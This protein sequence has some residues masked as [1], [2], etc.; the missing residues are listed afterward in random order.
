MAA[1]AAAVARP[2]PKGGLTVVSQTNE[3]QMLWHQVSTAKG[4]HRDTGS[5]VAAA[6]KKVGEAGYAVQGWKWA[7]TLLRKDVP[8]MQSIV[9]ELL[10]VLQRR[11]AISKDSQPVIWAQTSL[12]DIQPVA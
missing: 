1:K 3:E 10:E 9:N 8:A 5:T 2:G 4:E 6:W 11:G 12:D 7:M